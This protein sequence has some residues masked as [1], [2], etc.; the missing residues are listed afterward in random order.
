MFQPLFLTVIQL[1]VVL[2]SIDLEDDLFVYIPIAEKS[3]GALCA[4][5]LKSGMSVKYRFYSTFK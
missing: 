5:T 2:G 4:N 1:L 3:P